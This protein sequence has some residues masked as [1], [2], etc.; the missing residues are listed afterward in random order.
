[1]FQQPFRP[2]RSTTLSGLLLALLVAAGCASA[3]KEPPFTAAS[4]CNAP[5]YR[6]FDFWLG[7]WQVAAMGKPPSAVNEITRQAQGCAIR[8][9]Y[10]TESGY[11]GMSLNW[12]ADGAWHQ[13]WVDN[14]GLV[15]H[16]HG[17]LNHQGQ[18]VL[19]G[20]KRIDRQ[21]RPVQDRITWTPL[22]SGSVS[23]RWDISRNGGRGWETIFDGIY[24]PTSE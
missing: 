19:R 17:G 18:M 23:Q 16:L 1:M 12:Y 3:P 13:T 6:Q 22:A 4:A 5:E 20:E 2:A 24:T 8:E 11:T 10:A 9:Q 21:G 14:A 15:L 7:R